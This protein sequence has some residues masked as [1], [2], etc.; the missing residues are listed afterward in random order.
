MI[1]KQPRD[2]RGI[3]NITRCFKIKDRLVRVVVIDSTLLAEEPLTSL[4]RFNKQALT[5][6]V[7]P[8]SQKRK[9]K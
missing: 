6:W 1:V 3:K 5:L 7:V 4:Q 2:V 9:R 8:N